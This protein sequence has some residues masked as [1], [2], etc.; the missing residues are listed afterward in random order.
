MAHMAIGVDTHKDT[1]AA[2]L[3]DGIGT[4][5]DERAFRNDPAGHAAFVTWIAGIDGSVRVGVEGSSSYGAGLA[6]HLVAGD[7]DVAIAIRQIANPRFRRLL[8]PL[9]Y[10]PAPDVAD[11]AMESVQVAGKD[12]FIYVPTLISLLRNRRLKGRARAALALRRGP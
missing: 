7:M 1:L 2:C 4:A 5:R 9:L 6:R 3:V 12:D 11:E 8:I 10:D